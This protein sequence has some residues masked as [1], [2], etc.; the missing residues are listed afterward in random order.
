VVAEQPPADAE[1]HRP[2][3]AQEQLERRRIAVRDEAIEQLG[4]SSGYRIAGRTSTI[5]L[6]AGGAA[7]RK[8]YR[9]RFFS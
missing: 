2:V 7:K 5:G 1:H 8:Q 4:V 6:A 9:Y 3:L